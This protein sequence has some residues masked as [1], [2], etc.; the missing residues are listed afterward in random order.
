MG[1]EIVG[2][3]VWHMIVGAFLFAALAGVAYML[4]L[5]TLWL[6]SHGA[7]NHILF[8]AR[9]VTELLFFSDVLCFVLYIV[10]QTIGLL[11]LIWADL[12]R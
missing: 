7:P 11:R 2:R 12:R 6:E 3:F 10:G 1:W 9:V 4:W 5:G 8:A